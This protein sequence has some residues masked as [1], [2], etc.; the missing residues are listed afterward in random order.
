MVRLGSSL[1]VIA[2][3][4]LT[5]F[6]GIS[7]T[8][9]ANA[10]EEIRMGSRL[11]YWDVN[12]RLGGY[13]TKYGLKAKPV[14]FSTGIEVITA[15]QSGEIDIASSG[16]V[17]MTILMSKTDKVI[18]VGMATA[19]NGGIYRLVV[20]KDSKV[21]S[22]NDLKGKVIATKIG[23]GSYNA[24]LNYLGNKGLQEKDFKVKNAGPGAIVAAMESGSVDAGIWFDPTIA[25][26]LHRGL[27]RVVFD[28]E[29]QAESAGFWLVNRKFAEKNPDKVVRFLAG[30]MDSS[31]VLNN[32]PGAAAKNIAAGYKVR[33]FDYG[34]EVFQG[35]I[36]LSDYS[37]PIKPS[38]IATVK[39]TYKF[40]KGK[41]RIK[42]DEPDWN[43]LI[44]NQ[45]L[46]RAKAARK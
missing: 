41:G 29:G 9:E 22:I 27:G 24:L 23:S 30:A 20:P 15:I 10:D 5:V 32:D 37:V 17:P 38:N 12:Y 42:G 45:F 11:E 35:G 1:A 21:Q 39:N 4:A 26:I 14:P 13:D 36:H 19:N 40:F 7:V 34:A 43:E 33:G 28:F 16:H 8:T 18:A 6:T 46:E 2:L 44:N 31:D 3:A 25:L